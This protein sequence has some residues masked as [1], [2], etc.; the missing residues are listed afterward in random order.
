[1]SLKL[2]IL[3]S[4]IFILTLSG[5]F[6]ANDILQIDTGEEVHQFNVEVVATEEDKRQ[7]LMGC[8]SLTESGG[9]L[10]VYEEEKMQSF[11]MKNMIISLDILFIG[12]DLVINQISESVPPCAT[13]DNCISYPSLQP[14]Q[15]VLELNAGTAKKYGINVGD[16]IILP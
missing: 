5:C 6:S 15:Y 4:F 7:G 12:S 9:M 14:T 13:L 10:F 16:T 3:L 2:K 11:W 1:M 8:E